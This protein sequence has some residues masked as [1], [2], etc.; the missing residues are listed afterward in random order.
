MLDKNSET[1]ENRRKHCNVLVLQTGICTGPS[2]AC[3][4]H[5]LLLSDRRML[6]PLADGEVGTLGTSPLIMSCIDA[7]S[8]S[9]RADI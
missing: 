5:V 2:R 6:G 3:G 7:S 1:Y 4:H 9:T 8:E